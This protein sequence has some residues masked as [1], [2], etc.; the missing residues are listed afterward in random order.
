[1]MDSLRRISGIEKTLTFVWSIILRF[2]A[3]RTDADILKQVHKNEKG[4][5]SE[6]Y[7]KSLKSI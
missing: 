2:I 1:M 5:I 7:I 3:Q 6:I 4:L